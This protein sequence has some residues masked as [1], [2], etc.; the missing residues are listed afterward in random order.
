[1]GIAHY[2]HLAELS[3]DEYDA[4]IISVPHDLAGEL[5]KA[6]L[7]AGKPV[8]IEKPLGLSGEEARILEKLA[9]SLQM[10]SFVGFNYRFLPSVRD[11]M[12][13]IADGELGELRSIDMLIGH[14]GHPASAEGWKLD[15]TR[16][17]GG[18]LLDPGVHLL[19]L[20]MQ[21][22]PSAVC[23]AVEAT[24]GFWQTGIEEDVAATFRDGKLI[25]SIRISHIRWVN[26][27]RVEVFGEDGYGIAEGRGGNYGAI[28]LRVGQRW[29]WANVE[30]LSQRDTEVSYDFGLRDQSLRDELAAVVA[31]W[32]GNGL[33]GED[34]HPATMSEA[35]RVTELCDRLYERIG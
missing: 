34:S 9:T 23:T 32:R 25:A 33:P 22:A 24:R 19:D 13:A 10:P 27:F 20:L 16:A 28:T 4:A 1:M 2:A 30:G 12:S 35:R 29:G 14:G 18:V 21:L 8:L 31:C 17:G 15:P 26:T 6:V 3:V 5:A 7:R 11:L